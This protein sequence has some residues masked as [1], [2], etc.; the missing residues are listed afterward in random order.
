MTQHSEEEGK[1]PTGS[2]L[3]LERSGS[4]FGEDCRWLTLRTNGR[5]LRKPSLLFWPFLHRLLAV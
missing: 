5:E 4:I 3:S 1:V 2:V